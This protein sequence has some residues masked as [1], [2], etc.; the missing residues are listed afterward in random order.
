MQLT[1]C[2]R[3]QIVSIYKNKKFKVE[4]LTFKYFFNLYFTLDEII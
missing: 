3:K 4:T 1:Y 2:G